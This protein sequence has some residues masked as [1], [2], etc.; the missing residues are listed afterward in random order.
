MPVLA[1]LLLA[2]QVGFAYHAFRTG[3]EYFWIYLIIF[4]PGIGCILYFLT[5]VLPTMGQTRTARTAKNTLIKAI[6]PQRELRNRKEQLEISDSLENRLQ[7][8]N[9]CIEAGLYDDAISLYQ[10]CLEG[11]DA[12]NPNTMQN[13]AQAYFLKNNFAMCKQTLDELIE[14]N[15]DYRSTEGH[16]LYAKALEGLNETDKALEEYEILSTSYPGEE[17]RVRYGLLLIK[18]GQKEKANS[19][20][21][22]CLLRVKRAP[23]FYAKKEKEWVNIAKQ[24]A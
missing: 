6:D 8:A 2:I 16:L 15:P 18:L 5:Q 9:E 23:K 19:V 13:L 20:F 3:K 21:K 12:D 17:A 22:E 11:V 24:H 7:L 10:S 4:L 14:K 1:A